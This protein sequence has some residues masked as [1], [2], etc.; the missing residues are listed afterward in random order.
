MQLKTFASRYLNDAEKNYAI[1]E[2]E[3]LA[4]V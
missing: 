1:G 2:M 3:L 4:V